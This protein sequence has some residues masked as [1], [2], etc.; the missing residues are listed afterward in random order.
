MYKVIFGEIVSILKNKHGLAAPIINIHLPKRAKFERYLQ[1]VMA[2]ELK[3]KYA[4]T[5]IEKKYPNNKNCHVDVYA[6][7]TF[8]E[9]KTPNTNFGG[10]GRNITQNIQGIIN[11]IQKLRNANVDGVVAFVLFPIDNNSNYLQHVDK[12]K[13]QLG[14]N[15]YNECV[16][17][18][19]YVFSAKA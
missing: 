14:H 12:V 15:L 16:L 5:E 8:I 6:N 3:T 13:K 7:K 11:D 4:D 10:S 17:G 18:D 1:S 9:L 2:N 19:F